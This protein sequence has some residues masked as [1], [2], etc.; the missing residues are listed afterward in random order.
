VDE[1]GANLNGAARVTLFLRPIG[2][3]L[4][5]GMS[6]LAIAS[7]VQGGL[8]LRW[9]ATPE[10][11]HVGLILIAVPFVLQLLASFF[12]YLARDGASGAALGVLSVSWLGLGLIHLTSTPGSKSGA[13]GLMLL[14]SG[15]VLVL[16]ACAIGSTKPLPGLVFALTAARFVVSGV[17]ELGAGSFWVHL[18]GVLSLVVLAGAAYSVLA[19]ELEDQRHREVLPTFRRGPARAAIYNDARTQL[20][21]VVNEAGVRRTT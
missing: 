9:I 5:I 19:F 20:D 13:V 6:G 11:H 17:Y 1:S 12:S 8:D 16:S 14:A 10:T 18:A 21:G 7:L 15:G 3:P 4:T 2:A